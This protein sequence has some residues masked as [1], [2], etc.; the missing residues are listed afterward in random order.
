MKI[1]VT[2]GAGY[3]GSHCVA[4]LCNAG[5]EV[6][7]VDNLSEGHRQAVDSRATFLE[8]DIAETAK[9]TQ[10]MKEQGTEAVVHFAA[11][12]LVSESMAQPERYFR[13]NVA[14]GLSLLEA[15][16]AAGVKKIVFSST[17]A[18]YGIPE[19]AA[20][21]TEEQ[22]QKPVNPYGES[23]LMFEKMLHWF[24]DLHGFQQVTFRYFNAVGAGFGLGEDHRIETH[25]IPNV[26]KVA[27]GQQKQVSVFGND[28]PT[29]DG[30]AVRDYIHVKDLATIHR[31]AVERD[32][33]GSFNLGTGQ[34]SSVNEV[35]AACR[36]V[37]GEAIPTESR[38]RRPGDPPSL[39]A[40]NQKV[41]EAFD[42]QPSHDLHTSVR[43]A[44]QWH[45]QN[46]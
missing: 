36:Q 7:V 12:A 45:S 10:A 37:T 26:L 25:L 3:I 33:E 20:P 29:P 11:V 9:L 41:R 14:G 32:V 4:E 34:G 19:S 28:F 1:L 5:H 44:W 16:L 23:K 24:A 2:G 22:P 13:N 6:L 21:I 46:P 27:L 42:W 38:E 18:T 39:K 40:S 30:T 35:I 17:C 43:D 8:S 31:L 15:M